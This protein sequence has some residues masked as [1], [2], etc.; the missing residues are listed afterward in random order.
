MQGEG[1]IIQL[2]TITDYAIR[3]LL[4]LYEKRERPVIS[5]EEIS[6]KMGI[7]A[8]YLVKVARKL[9]E[10]GLIES[11]LGQFGGYHIREPADTISLY[12]VIQ[13][14]EPQKIN[15]CL[16]SGG[17]CSRNSAEDCSVRQFYEIMQEQ[18]DKSLKSMTLK[19]LTENTDRECLL[20]VL[21]KHGPPDREESS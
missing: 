16:E 12:D 19:V 13:V 8:S 9:R 20:S 2:K 11:V 5:S 7:P 3:T 21:K 1:Y 6:D 15:G 18:W 14:T 10:A 17:G 4:Y